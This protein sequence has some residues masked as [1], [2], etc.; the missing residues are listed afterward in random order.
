MYAQNYNHQICIDVRFVMSKPTI[1][2]EPSSARFLTSFL[3]APVLSLNDLSFCLKKRT[4]FE[5]PECTLIKVAL[6]IGFL[7]NGAYF[8]TKQTTSKAPQK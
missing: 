1:G 3:K 7:V 6:L 2:Y 8:M 5:G 4:L